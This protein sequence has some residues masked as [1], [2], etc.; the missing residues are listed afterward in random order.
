MH[1]RL[2]NFNIGRFEPEVPIF[3]IESYKSD[4]E[5]FK[6]IGNWTYGVE[7]STEGVIKHAFLI[8]RSQQE[9]F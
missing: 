7:P 1:P 3:D 9:Y 4:M 5:I 2:Y 6:S 8:T